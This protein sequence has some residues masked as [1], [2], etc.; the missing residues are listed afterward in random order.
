MPQFESVEQIRH[1]APGGIGT[2][3]PSWNTGFPLRSQPA[4]GE[5]IVGV[6]RPGQRL[7]VLELRGGHLRVRLEADGL[8]GWIPAHVVAPWQSTKS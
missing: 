6:A 1:V 3:I 8:E 4:P 5:P 7:H 2:L